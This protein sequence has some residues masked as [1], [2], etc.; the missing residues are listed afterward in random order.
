[1]SR[2][3]TMFQNDLHKIR[4]DCVGELGEGDDIHPGPSW[5]VGEGIIRLDVV[6]EGISRQGQWHVVTPPSVVVGR[7]I[8]NNVH[9]GTNVRHHN[10]LDVEVG[11]DGVFVRRRVG[12]DLRG[13][14]RRRS[15]HQGADG[16]PRHDDA[17]RQPSPQ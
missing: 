14:G 7:G 15:P 11:D 6:D 4:G 9:E 2:G 12:H 16:W 5:V 10:R 17:W 1:V 13:R 3:A 8:Q